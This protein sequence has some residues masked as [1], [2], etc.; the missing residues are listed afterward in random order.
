LIPALI[1]SWSLVFG[2]NRTFP[3]GSNVIFNDK[4]F[5]VHKSYG[6]NE[7]ECNFETTK[8]FMIEYHRKIGA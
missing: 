3:R 8:I 6:I 7:I 2:E 1:I 5:G 4:F